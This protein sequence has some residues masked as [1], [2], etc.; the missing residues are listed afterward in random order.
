MPTSAKHSDLTLKIH[1]SVF[2]LLLILAATTILGRTYRHR[3]IS[4]VDLKPIDS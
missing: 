4:F 2:V 1:A 3:R